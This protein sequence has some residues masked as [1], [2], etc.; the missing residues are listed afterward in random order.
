MSN[1]SEISTN[2]V[3]ESEKLIKKTSVVI[4]TS[5]YNYT[6]YIIH[7]DS[8]RLL[9]VLN[10][11]SAVDHPELSPDFL[12][13]YDIKICS[14]DGQREIISPNSLMAK[15]SILFVGENE[16]K[17]IEIPCLNYNRLYN[18][19]SKKTF[20]VEIH[21][22]SLFIIGRVH[23]EPRQ[24]LIGALNDNRRFL[25]ITNAT[26]SSRPHARAAK[27]EFIAVNRGQ[28]SYICKME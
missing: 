28:I 4:G 27:F 18:F 7:F 8:E 11:G 5:D 25:P 3:E 2:P 21:M 12:Q 20:P 26:L 13:V 9:D 23:I 19:T 10:Q 24:I 22:P 15:N 1:R 14:V 17:G 16:T 6:G